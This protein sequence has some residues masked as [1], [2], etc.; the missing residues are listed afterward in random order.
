[1]R[2]QCIDEAKAQE[3]R[4]SVE[5]YLKSH[6]ISYIEAAHRL[7][8]KNVQVVYNQLHSGRFGS[9][10]APRWAKTFGFSTDYLTYGRGVLLKRQSGYRKIAKENDELR[11]IV[12]AQKWRIEDQQRIID[13]LKEK[14][15][16]YNN[17]NLQ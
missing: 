11:A 14:L 17:Y 2:K 3:V 8:Y 15:L 16:K 10:S 5:R 7:G 13:E 1:M 12:R 9:V 6:G 4:R